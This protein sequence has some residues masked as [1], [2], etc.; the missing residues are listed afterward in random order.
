MSTQNIKALLYESIE[1]INDEDFLLAVKQILD[2]K[3]LP[4][5][6][7]NLAPEQIQ[8]IEESK[9]QILEGNSLTNEQ[10]DQLVN[11]WLKE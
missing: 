11:K 4:V 1:N 5:D 2:R 6:Q 10:A 9:Q 8:R 3:Y 7:P